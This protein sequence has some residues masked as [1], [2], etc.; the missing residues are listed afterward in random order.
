MKSCPRLLDWLWLQQHVD[1]GGK[2]LIS[3]PAEAGQCADRRQPHSSLGGLVAKMLNITT[4]RGVGLSR[5]KIAYNSYA[6][7][8]HH[9]SATSRVSQRVFWMR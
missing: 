6:G 4:W 8:T 3:R 5:W 9:L 2:V 1:Q 7:A